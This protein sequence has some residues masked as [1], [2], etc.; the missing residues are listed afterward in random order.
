[1]ARKKPA[2]DE[3]PAREGAR[4]TAVS[5]DGV[6]G[7]IIDIDGSEPRLPDTLSDVEREI[8]ALVL[9]GCSGQEI[10]A[11]RG[12]SYRTIANQLAAIYRKCGVNSRAELVAALSDEDR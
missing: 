11:R 9:D 8:V 2:T 5:F 1:M 6:P 10:A 12:R 3:E 7:L 4:I